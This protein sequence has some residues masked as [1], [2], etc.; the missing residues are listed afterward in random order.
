MVVKILKI[1]A[2][3]IPCSLRR[4]F[5]RGLA[6]LGYYL[7]VRHRLI[8]L[9]NLSRSF[10]GKNYQE[11][12]TIAK[13]SYTSFARI[14]A[15]FPDILYLDKNNF[16]KW[17]KIIGLDNYLAAQRKGRGVILFGAHYGNWEM[18]NAA[19]ALATSPFIFV[20]R[21]LDNPIMEEI[22]TGVRSSY[23]NISLSKKGNMR[24]MIGLLRQGKTINILIDQNVFLNEGV[25]VD[26]FGRKAATTSG[27]ALL[28]IYTGAAVLPV[29]SSRVPD[30]RYLLEIGQK[31]DIIDTGNR[32]ADVLANTQKFTMI[33]EEQIK[34]NPE[35]W[36]WLH[37][38]WKTK[39]WQARRMNR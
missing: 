38:R 6:R 36:L 32:D 30:G 13:K 29:F 10:P 39:P 16:S 25:F 11:I 9:H 20:Y 7:S 28:A 2:L 3:V 37:R 15:E 14:I 23:G 31:V 35:Q 19:L 24:K 34:K 18:G 22:I 33:I 17:V 21:I 5:I 12:I 4:L 26:F 27:V 8:A 1:L